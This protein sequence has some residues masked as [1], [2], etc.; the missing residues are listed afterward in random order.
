MDLKSLCR[1]CLSIYMTVFLVIIITDKQINCI[2]AKED[3]WMKIGYEHKMLIMTI[4]QTFEE[5]KG[6]F[7]FSFRSCNFF[8]NVIFNFWDVDFIVLV[9]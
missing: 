2:S 4:I 5:V 1:T 6:F 9:K 3:D 7:R 8:G